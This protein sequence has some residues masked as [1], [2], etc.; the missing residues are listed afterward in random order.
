[1]GFSILCK[2]KHLMNQ[3]KQNKQKS[4][5]HLNNQNKPNAPITFYT[6]IHSASKKIICKNDRNVG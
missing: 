1:M 2:I 4:H 3:D 5:K 6:H